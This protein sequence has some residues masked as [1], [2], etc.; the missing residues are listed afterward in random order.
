MRDL[1]PSLTSNRSILTETQ[2]DLP[3]GITQS[4]DGKYFIQILMRDD[5]Q[6]WAEIISDPGKTLNS[7]LTV[8]WED[9]EEWED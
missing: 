2:E 3:N 8:N 7:C 5:T 9:G 6:L 4:L 1:S